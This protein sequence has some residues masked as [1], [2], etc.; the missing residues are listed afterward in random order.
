VLTIT[1]GDFTFAEDLGDL[2]SPGV[3][4]IGNQTAGNPVNIITTPNRQHFAG[5]TL[6]GG[7]TTTVTARNLAT[8][9]RPTAKVLVVGALS[10]DA[11]S[12]IDLRNNDLV[13]RYAAGQ[14]TT[15]LNAVKTL[16]T[17]GYN[18]GDFL[19]SGITST[20]AAVDAQ[21]NGFVGIGYLDNADIGYTNFDSET[22]GGAGALTGNEILVKYTWTADSDLNGQVDA[23]DYGQFLFGRAGGGTGWLNGDFDYSNGIDAT[24]YGQFQTGISAFRRPA[25]QGGGAL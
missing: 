21:I 12:K 20:D 22:S 4:V 14:G 5:L 8:V 25:A 2:T 3:T 24:D 10:V 17:R 6:T 16:I 19:G 23:T 7:A 1:K 9:P 13:V 18:N 11:T 15:T